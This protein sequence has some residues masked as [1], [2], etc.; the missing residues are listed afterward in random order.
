MHDL[1]GRDFLSNTETKELLFNSLGGEQCVAFFGVPEYIIFPTMLTGPVFCTKVLTNSY[2]DY[3]S[4]ERTHAQTRD[5]LCFLAAALGMVRTPATPAAK[6]SHRSAHALLSPALA[7][8]L[9][10]TT[11]AL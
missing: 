11:R 6:V 5:L 1:R 9:S 8:Q 7:Y 2:H 10:L 4:F 3:P